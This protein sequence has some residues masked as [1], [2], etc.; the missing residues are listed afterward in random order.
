MKKDSPQY[1]LK[2]G[3][4]AGE[5]LAKILIERNQDLIAQGHR[6]EPSQVSQAIDIT[7]A[8]MKQRGEIPMNVRGPRLTAFSDPFVDAL[9][10]NGLF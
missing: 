5:D 9:R 3:T 8:N 10:R 1:L 4:K 7:V 6:L 2:L